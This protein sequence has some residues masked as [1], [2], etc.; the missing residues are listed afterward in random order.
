[1]GREN[2]AASSS[3]AEPGR[4]K[5][6]NRSPRTHPLRALVSPRRKGH[7]VRSP[8]TLAGFVAALV[9]VLASTGIAV[10]RMTP[11]A[12]VSV[13]LSAVTDGAPSA[14]PTTLKTAAADLLAATTAKGGTGYRFEIVQ[15]ATQHARPGGPALL[16]ADPAAPD[17]PP[18]EVDESYVIGLVETGYV[19]P[20]GFYMEMRAGPASAEAPV[21]LVAGELMF[22]ALV[23]GG[24][25]YRDDGEGWYATDSPPG[26]GL[27][28][29]TAAALPGLLRN[30][31]NPKEADLAV[32]KG[33]LGRSR[34][35]AARGIT[36]DGAVAD[37]PGV[38]AVDGASFT[39]I[40]AP[41]DFTFDAA[42][43]LV[44]LVVTARNANA[45]V[46]DLAVV[47]KITLRYDDVPTAL[48]KPEPA[49]AGDGTPV[50]V[51]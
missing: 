50:T 9:V 32:A 6:G 2:Q 38:I 7:V 5:G 44:G 42:G 29:V 51:P 36:A 28:P 23:R 27:D 34:A 4:L 15:R 47:T 8:G 37:I 33:E 30:A 43:R 16:V 31:R 11:P 17:S 26:I 19:T 48:P 20:A 3:H 25:T 39:Q 41:L 35:D 21:D 18:N 1:M 10:A 24:V 22:R 12:T 46:H 40:T 14:D 45:T 49:Y 13:P